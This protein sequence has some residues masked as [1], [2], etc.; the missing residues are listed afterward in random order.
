MSYGLKSYGDDGYI[1]LHSDYSSLVYAGEMTESASPVRPVY[2]GS[3]AISIQ[4]YEKNTNYDQGWV[5]QFTIDLNVDYL[6]PF[7]RPNYNGQEVGILDV[8]NEGTTWVVNLVFGGSNTNKPRVFAFAPLTELPSSQVTINNYGAVVYDGSGDLTF[9]DAMQPLRVDDVL[10]ISHPSSIRTAA[11]GSCANSNNC[12]VNFTSDQSTTYTGSTSNTDAKIY[13]VVPSA[14]GGLAFSNDGSFSRSC[15]FFGLGNRPYRWAYKSWASFRGA[16]KHPYGLASH[17]TGWL[18]DFSGGVHQQVSGDCGY[19]GFL[20]ALIGIAAV[21]F[22]GGIGL[23]VLGGALTGFVIGELTVASAPS[24]RAYEQDG[25]FDQ[26]KSYQLIMTDAS[27]YGINTTPSTQGSLTSN[28]TYYYNQFNPFWWWADVDSVLPNGTT[29]QQYAEIYWDDTEITDYANSIF[30]DF[31]GYSYTAG[32]NTYY[33]GGTTYL[34][35]TDEVLDANNNPALIV[36][37]SLK[38]VART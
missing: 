26:N 16:V 28:L 3:N 23:A 5:M 34:L 29:S 31:D 22:T 17:T 7:Y 14:Y 9:T 21:V 6:I 27:Y 11:R 32:G 19:S 4:D 37:Y 30:A 20:G 10:T 15:G 36:Y 1:N 38:N 2:A 18:G 13:H 12:H 25:V 35:I 33:K 24:L 8:V